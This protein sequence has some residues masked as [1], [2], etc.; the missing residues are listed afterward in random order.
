MCERARSCW[1]CVSHQGPKASSHGAVSCGPPWPKSGDL[2]CCLGPPLQTWG[3]VDC[4]A[5]G[6]VQP[7]DM[8][9]YSQ[10]VLVS[11]L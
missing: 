7:P 4:Q 5:M 8:L 9:C 2:L 3:D 6:W 1:V 10:F 11:N